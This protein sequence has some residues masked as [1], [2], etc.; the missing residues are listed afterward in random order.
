MNYLCAGTEN[1]LAIVEGEVCL[2]VYKQN[3]NYRIVRDSLDRQVALIK[4][5]EIIF[6]NYDTSGSNLVVITKYGLIVV[7]KFGLPGQ[8]MQAID[9]TN[10]YGIQTFT[11]RVVFQNGRIL[12]QMHA[13]EDQF[14]MKLE[15]DTDATILVPFGLIFENNV[16]LVRVQAPGMMSQFVR[17][18]LLNK[19]K[20]YTGRNWDWIVK[21]GIL[22]FKVQQGIVYILTHTCLIDFSLHEEEPVPLIVALPPD[23]VRVQLSATYEA[24]ADEHRQWRLKGGKKPVELEFEKHVNV[25]RPEDIMFED[26]TAHIGCP[27]LEIAIANRVFLLATDGVY[28]YIGTHWV[29][30]L[31]PNTREPICA[32]QILASKNALYYQSGNE[33]WLSYGHPKPPSG[34]LLAVYDH[35]TVTSREIHCLDEPL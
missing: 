6:C 11:M 7:F 34:E 9:G 24:N 5:Q 22:D 2:V 19:R 26:T 16:L 18:D 8:R 20:I 25:I 32:E 17:L 28:M 31:D 13:L 23:M 10:H 27:W 15:Q 1:A 30:L 3:A 29:Q 35:V 21:Q 4:P 14:R 33:S 12:D